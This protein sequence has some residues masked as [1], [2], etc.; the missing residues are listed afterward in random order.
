MSASCLVCID[1]L[2]KG[3][4]EQLEQ[5]KIECGLF[6]HNQCEVLPNSRSLYSDLQKTCVKLFPK[7][8]V[9]F[10]Q[11]VSVGVVSIAFIFFFW[12]GDESQSELVLV[13]H[14]ETIKFVS[15]TRLS[16][17][18]LYEIDSIGEF[19]VQGFVQSISYFDLWTK[20]VLAD[21]SEITQFTLTLLQPS[22]LEVLLE[23]GD[24]VIAWVRLGTRVVGESLVTAEWWQWS[25]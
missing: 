11:V 23:P 25:S 19:F 20:I 17:L 3:E 9:K 13:E 6:Q 24:L 10:L 7:E 5:I 12:S 1:K 16:I 22:D 18:E 8:V 4:L 14:Q 15:D 21:T 2:A